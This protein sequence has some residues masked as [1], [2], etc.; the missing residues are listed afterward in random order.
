MP[1]NYRTVV[2][3]K[4]NGIGIRLAG[5]NK[6]GIFI[7]DVQYNSPAE[8]AGLRIGDKI[9]KVNGIDYLSLTREEAVNNMLNSTHSLIEM[10]VAHTPD[11]YEANAFDPLGG[12]SFYVRC[13]FNYTSKTANDINFAI[14]DILHVTDT[15]YNGVIGQWVASKLDSGEDARGTMPNET[16]AEKL[17]SNAPTIDQLY[18]INNPNGSGESST[19]NDLKSIGAS[20]RMSIRMKLA[21]RNGLAKRSKSASR[22]NGAPGSDNESNSNV[23]P[24]VKVSKPNTFHS[25]KYH[26]YE[27]IV[28]KEGKRLK[29][30]FL[31]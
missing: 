26:T 30:Y 29:I 23:N 3:A 16:S 31:S 14:N 25:D 21:G 17:V 9:I 18:S 2:F 24:N 13:H 8:R 11:E 7:C 22:T 12:D 10:V 19:T 27:R 1:L 5:G 15:L 20:A 4:E 28:L 6:V